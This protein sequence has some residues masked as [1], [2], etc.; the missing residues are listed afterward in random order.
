MLYCVVLQWVYYG[1]LA[2]VKEQDGAAMSMGRLDAFLDTYFEADLQAGQITEEKVQEMI[3]QFVMKLRIVRCGCE[4]NCCS[5]SAGRSAARLCT[6]CGCSNLGVVVDRGHLLNATNPDNRHVQTAAMA[7][8]AHLAALYSCFACHA[9]TTEHVCFF[10]PFFRWFVT[11]ISFLS[12]LAWFLC[13]ILLIYVFCLG[14]CRQLRTPEYNELFAGD[15]TWVTCVLGGTDIEGRPMVTKTTFRMV[16]TQQQAG[17]M[18][19]LMLLAM[20]F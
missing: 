3:D 5:A 8:S 10:V 11:S 17:D 4:S 16:S 13:I 2:A 20:L 12:C 15:P 14:A 7:R 6:A 1:Y 9:T 19:N 18:E